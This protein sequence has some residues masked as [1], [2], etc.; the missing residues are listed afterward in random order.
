MKICSTY[1]DD[2]VIIHNVPA[3]IHAPKDPEKRYSQLFEVI[4]AIRVYK[5]DEQS[6]KKKNAAR[7]LSLSPCIEGA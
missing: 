6:K 5:K 2:S 7:T 3:L 1:V 4:L